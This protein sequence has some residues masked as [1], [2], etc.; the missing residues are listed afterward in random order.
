VYYLS[1]R[2]T[3][4]ETL[5][6]ELET[7]AATEYFSPALLSEVY[8]A[9][10]DADNGFVNLQRAMDA[11]AREMIFLQVNR[12]LDGWHDDPRYLDLV[13]SIGFLSPQ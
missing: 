2:R 1:G 9:A 10:G 7:I 3:E 6:A 11:R 4:A 5:L 8:F 12:S 13:R